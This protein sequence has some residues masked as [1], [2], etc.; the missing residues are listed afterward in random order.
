[1]QR[2]GRH[3]EEQIRR[4]ARL[5]QLDLTSLLWH[6]EIGEEAGVEREVRTETLRLGEN[7][8]ESVAIAQQH[9][10]ARHNAAGVGH[11]ADEKGAPFAFLAAYENVVRH[12][13][14]RSEPRQREGHDVDVH[15][16]HFG[17]QRKRQK[18]ERLVAN[19]LLRITSRATIPPR[20]TPCSEQTSLSGR[21]TSR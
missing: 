9:D 19:A 18:A 13:E 10:L 6:N 2:G 12:G 17:R 15:S 21:R 5:R 7:R 1:M 16:R 11:F 20:R 4:T 8:K 14:A 3:E